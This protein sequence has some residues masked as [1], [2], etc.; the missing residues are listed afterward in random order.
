MPIVRQD[1]RSRVGINWYDDEAEAVAVAQTLHTQYDRETIQ[2][3]N[4]GFIQVG[5]D[6]SFD[7]VV[8]GRPAYAVVVP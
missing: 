2:Q 5:R 6:R 3:A 7:T 8:D 1:S 4:M